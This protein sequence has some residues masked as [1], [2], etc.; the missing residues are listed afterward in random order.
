MG[1]IGERALK[2]GMSSWQLSRVEQVQ[3]EMEFHDHNIGNYPESFCEIYKGLEIRLPLGTYRGERDLHWLVKYVIRQKSLEMFCGI[4]IGNTKANHHFKSKRKKEKE[5]YKLGRS[6]E[7][8]NVMD[9]I[10]FFFKQLVS[11]G[12]VN[13]AVGV[14]GNF[15]RKYMR[16]W[17]KFKCSHHG[18]Y[19]LNSS[20]MGWWRGLGSTEIDRQ[21][22]KHTGFFAVDDT[23]CEPQ[24]LTLNGPL[25]EGNPGTVF[26]EASP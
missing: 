10:F 5:Y 13:K 24:C 14:E 6:R 21:D 16:N 11:L 26:P 3:W 4:D 1:I 18:R 25:A 23:H 2:E 8:L 17:I 15:M 19:S 22:N 7:N 20:K 12:K 9:C